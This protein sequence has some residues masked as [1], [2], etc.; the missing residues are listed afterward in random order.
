MLSRIKQN[1]LI[2]TIYNFPGAAW[3]YHFLWAIFGA[4]IYRFPSKHIFVIGIT[5]TKGKTTTIE[6]L[7]AILEAA[8]KKTALL[9][10]LRVK[11]GGESE[12]N[13]IGN[14]MPGRF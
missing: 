8:G 7:S 9:S 14:T 11:I 10:S 1:F 3:A 12:K 4:L 5:G 2:R 13:R 6:L